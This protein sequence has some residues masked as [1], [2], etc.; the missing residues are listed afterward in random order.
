[1]SSKTVINVEDFNIIGK[2]YKNSTFK[3]K[4]AK[5]LLIKD[6]KPTFNTHKKSVPLMLFNW[7]DVCMF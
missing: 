2:S 6:V 5:S 7:Y 1:M 4:V 3:Q